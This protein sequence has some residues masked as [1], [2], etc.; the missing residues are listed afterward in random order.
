MPL[1]TRIQDVLPQAT[2]GHWP[3]HFYCIDKTTLW[4]CH[5]FIVLALDRASISMGASD[6]SSTGALSLPMSSCIFIFD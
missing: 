6:Y 2:A 3:N 4:W 1:L 5:A